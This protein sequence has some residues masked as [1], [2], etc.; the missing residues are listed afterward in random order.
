MASREVN[1]DLET[2]NSDIAAEIAANAPG[3]IPLDYMDTCFEIK[4]K[5]NCDVIFVQDRTDYADL[6]GIDVDQSIIY[7]SLWLVGG[8]A[9]ECGDDTLVVAEAEYAPGD[10]WQ[11]EDLDEGKYEVRLRL[12][13]N[14]TV[15]AVVYPNT[16]KE[17]TLT[18]TLDCCSDGIE[19]LKTDLVEK[20]A[21]LTCTI[22]DY[23]YIGRDY[24]ALLNNQYALQGIYTAITSPFI[25]CSDFQIFKC[26]ADK[27]ITNCNC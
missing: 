5:G 27:I 23:G 11:Y 17:I 15:D 26:K 13:Y 12:D 20:I 24:S 16:I 1:I 9:C 14:V 7:A 2:I 21:K 4:T 6:T 19:D 8:C 10:S 18:S 25:N 3:N 22:K